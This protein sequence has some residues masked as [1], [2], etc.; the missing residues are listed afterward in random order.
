LQPRP[1]PGRPS[2][3]RLQGVKIGRRY[4]VNIPSRLTEVLEPLIRTYCPQGGLVLDPFCGSGS[5]LVAAEACRRRYVGIELDGNHVEA[6]R[7]R[8]PPL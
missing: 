3:D 4:G 8:L 2:A 7:K 5:S 1:A 6:A